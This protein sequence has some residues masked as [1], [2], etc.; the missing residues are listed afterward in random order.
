LD[1]QPA[2]KQRQGIYTKEMI[3]VKKIFV[4]S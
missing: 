3:E 1:D 4:E 2:D